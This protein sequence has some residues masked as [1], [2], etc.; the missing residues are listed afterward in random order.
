MNMIE[1][2]AKPCSRCGGRG[3]VRVD[4]RILRNKAVK[5][6]YVQCSACNQKGPGYKT[7]WL[8]ED[9]CVDECIKAWNGEAA[10]Q[11]WIENDHKR[12]IS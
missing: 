11:E 3:R 8:T 1:L 4:I 6:F 7:S 10:E 12:G 2:G 5:E 9:E